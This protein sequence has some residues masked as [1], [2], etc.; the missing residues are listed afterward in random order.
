MY[1]SG[2]KSVTSLQD[3]IWKACLLAEIINQRKDVELRKLIDK[4][5]IPLKFEPIEHYLI[6]PGAWQHVGDIGALAHQVFAHPD[7]LVLLPEVSQYYRGMAL[8]SRKQVGQLAT[9]VT[10]WEE[11]KIRRTIRPDRALVVS[12]VYNG[13][14]SSMIEGS[15]NWTLENGFRNIIATMGIRLDGVFR[16]KIG[17]VAEN[18][19]KTK[20]LNWAKG[21]GI[22]VKTVTDFE[23]VLNQNIVMKFGSDPDI[24]FTKDGLPVA[25]VEIKGGKDPA[26]ALERLGAMSKSFAET[27]PGCVNF[28]VAGVITPEMENRLKKFATVRVFL[29]DEIVSGSVW[30]T[31]KQE[32]FHYTLR[33]I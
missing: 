7:L 32:I 15:F 11:G 16:N 5:D 30:E 10:P 31:F 8:L 21:I 6:S 19:I 1:I 22:V 25:T 17:Q 12:R 20:I 24:L 23:F 4:T 3:A 33:L 2:S 29:H 9:D 28:F 26:G 13:V 27:P 18:V 14:L